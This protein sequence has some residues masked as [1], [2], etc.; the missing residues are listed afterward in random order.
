MAEDLFSIAIVCYN[1]NNYIEQCIDSVLVQN[2]PFIELII[3]DDFSDNF[4]KESLQK[5]INKKIIDLDIKYK[6]KNI[7][8]FRQK[9]NMGTVKNCNTACELA[10]GKLF[11]LLAA[12]DMLYD[13]NVLKNISL[14]FQNL[15]VNVLCGRGQACLPDGSLTQ[16]M[17]PTD[18]EYKKMYVCNMDNLLSMLCTLPWSSIF[19]PGVAFRKSFLESM[20]KF[21]TSYQYIEDWPLWIKIC[22]SGY[23][24]D[25]VDLIVVK[26][27]YGGISTEGGT[28]QRIKLKKL[29]YCEC[30]DLFKKILYSTVKNKFSL[31]DVIKCKLSLQCFE[32][33][34]LLEYEWNSTS[35]LRKLILFVKTLPGFIYRKL[36]GAIGNNKR[37]SVKNDLTILICLYLV[38]SVSNIM[39]LRFLIGKYI[40]ILFV[41]ILLF[42]LIANSILK[43]IQTNI[44]K[45]YERK[46]SD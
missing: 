11:K 46:I 30:T 22:T 17:Y 3:C 23:K 4:D 35:A 42:K 45:K 31:V 15:Q 5:Y 16:Y 26:Y 36:V 8:I 28:K 1:Q 18:T 41:A 13:E 38:L 37:F 6:I 34:I 27:R 20:G 2:Y 44:N 33:K 21:D 7:I 43:L 12:D 39:N 32:R 29:F 10:T 14:Y 25:F 9:Q 19:A 40:F 24:I